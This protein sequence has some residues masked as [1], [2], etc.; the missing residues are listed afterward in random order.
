[1]IHVNKLVNK[2]KIAQVALIYSFRGQYEGD[3][4]KS[5]Q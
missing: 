2:V 4:K 3:I 1:M 5:S